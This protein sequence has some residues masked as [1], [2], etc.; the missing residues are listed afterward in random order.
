MELL[1]VGELSTDKFR[2]MFKLTYNGDASLVIQTKVQVSL[3]VIYR[4][5]FKFSIDRPI[6]CIKNP[7]YPDIY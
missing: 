6:P 7:I 5:R 1:E 3:I 2:G 4:T